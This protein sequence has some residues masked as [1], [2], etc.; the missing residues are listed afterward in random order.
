VNAL[1]KV[2]L[3]IIR[4][5]AAV[6]SGRVFLCLEFEVTLEIAEGNIG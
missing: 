2:E 5:Y 3:S 1:C 6:Y 4:A